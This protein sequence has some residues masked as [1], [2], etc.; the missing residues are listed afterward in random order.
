M[1]TMPAAR[2]ISTAERR[3]RLGV[4]HHLAPGAGGRDVAGVAR[5]LVALHATDPA[6]VF[7]SVRA[8]LPGVEP[9]DVERALYHERTVLRMLGMRR[10]MFVV[11]VETAPM[12]QAA[13]TVR[14]A[15]DE[16]KRLLQFIVDSGLGP[17]A[18]GWLHRV[19]AETVA[20]LAARGEATA[21]EIAQEVPDLR[22]QLTLGAGTKWETVQAASGRVLLLLGSEGQI[23]RGKPR[24]TWI[25]SQY[26][27]A[28][29][30]SWV[31]G[32]M[33]ALAPDAAR[34]DLVRQWLHAFGP[35]T[36]GDLKWWTG[37]TMAQTRQALS[38]AGAVQVDLGGATGYVLHDDLDPVVA[39]DP[40]VALVPALDATVMG[41]SERAWYLGDHGPALFDRSGNPGPS[42]WSDGRIVGGWAQ[43]RDGSVVYRLLE[44]VGSAAIAAIDA[45]TEGLAAWM[46]P[47]RVTPRFRTPL[48]R[49]LSG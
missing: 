6:T 3:A 48:E 37:W 11:P 33:P 16:R 42:V 34:S 38:E 1:A 28:P 43:R 7:L 22:Q 13:C 31:P 15:A 45:A 24:G 18:A 27:W 12:V 14:I 49:E 39:D 4:R 40:W 32:G 23:V 25:S 41:W 19:E 46:G 2:S 30:D 17:D 26:R 10:T 35:G 44:D 36:A 29:M 21:T 8:R 5:S 47:V 9:A 20:A